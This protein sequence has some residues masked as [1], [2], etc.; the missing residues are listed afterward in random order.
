V[1][2]D[3]QSR[4]RI[5]QKYFSVNEEYANRHKTEI[6]SANFRLKQTKFLIQNHLTGQWTRSN[7]QKTIYATFPLKAQSIDT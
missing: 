4:L 3:G 2:L 1:D 5:R 6:I 7:G